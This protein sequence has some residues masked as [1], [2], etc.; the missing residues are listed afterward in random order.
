MI[1]QLNAFA[2]RKLELDDFSETYQECT[3]GKALLAVVV[4][5]AGIGKTSFLEAFSKQIRDVQRVPIIAMARCDS[6]S[7]AQTPYHVLGQILPK[8]LE[9][10]SVA[11]E[12]SRDEQIGKILRV[13]GQLFKNFAPNLLDLVLPGAGSLIGKGTELIEQLNEQ[14]HDELISE[15]LESQNDQIDK[16]SAVLAEISDIQPLVLIV[17]DAHLADSISISVLHRLLSSYPTAPIM[18][19]VGLRPSYRQSTADE[20]TSSLEQLLVINR[21]ADCDLDNLPEEERRRFVNDLVNMLPHDLNDDF[22][23]QLFKRT[24]GHPLLA[25]ELLQ[26][27]A[28]KNSLVQ[29]NNGL[30]SANNDIQWDSAPESLRDALVQRMKVLPSEEQELL[31]IASVFDGELNSGIA[32]EFLKYSDWDVVRILTRALQ[33]HYAILRETKAFRIGRELVVGFRF[34]EP[35]FREYVYSTLGEGERMYIH[36][37]IAT[38]YIDMFGLNV[39][40]VA[41]ELAWHLEQA[42]RLQ[43]AVELHHKTA[44]SALEVG[45]LAE[46]IIHINRGIDCIDGLSSDKHRD[47]LELDLLLLKSK[48]LKARDGWSSVTLDQINTRA[49]EL[50]RHCGKFEQIESILMSE[51]SSCVARADLK[52]SLHTAEQLLKNAL[53]S[54]DDTSLILGHAIVANSKFWLGDL[55]GANRHAQD[56]LAKHT[57]ELGEKMIAKNGFDPI[58][59]AQMFAVWTSHLLGNYADVKEYTQLARNTIEEGHPFSSVIAQMT[60]CWQASHAFDAKLTLVEATELKTMAQRGEFTAYQGLA[61]I[62]TGWAL[63]IDNNEYQAGLLQLDQGASV[64]YASSGA[65]ISTYRAILRFDLLYAVNNV[66]EI[67]HEL[68]YAF[69]HAENTNERAYEAELWRLRGDFLTLMPAQYQ[70]CITA[71]SHSADLAKRNG[72]RTHELAALAKLLHLTE[73][74]AKS[75]T[76]NRAR[77]LVA[78]LQ[79]DEAISLV[80]EVEAMINLKQKHKDSHD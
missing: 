62:F 52:S 54:Q 50:A 26:G 58:V 5:Q 67:E 30:W 73:G 45:A 74:E 68:A 35:I 75:K 49:G 21:S 38:G 57:P 48:V 10:K 7:R 31:R 70:A 77:E 24:D 40:K 59:I 19:V 15:V 55:V 43:E 69:E 44:Q 63:A 17:D 71:Y 79:C 20:E 36:D 28:S 33:N 18:L 11:N 13:S 56:A 80:T 29:K 25:K 9:S 60:I 61:D 16:L 72:A 2:G 27:L 78:Q 12:F 4:G 39:D 14:D 64:W 22:T 41:S 6:I 8:L 42:G 53:I 23:E 66:D 46:S 51:W 32:G 76:V 34:R 65:L 47:Q 37:A 1:T 3:S